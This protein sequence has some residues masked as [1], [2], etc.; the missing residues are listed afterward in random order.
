[1]NG[2]RADPVLIWRAPLDWLADGEGGSTP[3]RR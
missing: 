3:A 1:M 2:E